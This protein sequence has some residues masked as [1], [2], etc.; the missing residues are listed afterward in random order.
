M[1]VNV[2]Q[3]LSPILTLLKIYGFASIQRPSPNS[4]KLT[5]VKYY[6]LR[7]YNFLCSLMFIGVLLAIFNQLHIRYFL[8]YGLPLVT[9]YVFVAN[10]LCTVVHVSVFIYLNGI[11]LVKSK[12]ID[13]FYQ[14]AADIDKTLIKLG[15]MPSYVKSYWTNVMIVAISSIVFCILGI[16]TLYAV[17]LTAQLNT[18]VHEVITSV[19]SVLVLYG[20]VAM[21]LVPSAYVSTVTLRFNELNG[22]F[23]W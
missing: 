19:P 3:P 4:S 21:F 15:Q 23:S 20:Y 10:N 13:S 17:S 11:V 9:S 14:I 22:C 8:D 2:T 12:Y 5:W 6:C 16:F 1:T 7:V 18:P